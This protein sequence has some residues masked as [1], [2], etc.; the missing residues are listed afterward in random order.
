MGFAS[1]VLPCSH[2]FIAFSSILITLLEKERADCS[3][4]RALVCL[5][6]VC[7]FVYFSVPLSAMGLLGLVIMAT[8]KAN[9]FHTSG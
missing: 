9:N 2:I 4:Y 3:A 7:S 6:C 1:S 5:F 8:S